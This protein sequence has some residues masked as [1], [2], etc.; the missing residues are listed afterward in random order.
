MYMKKSNFDK[1]YPLFSK[2]IADEQTRK[3]MLDNKDLYRK[4]Q[5]NYELIR[6]FLIELDNRF[7]ASVITKIITEIIFKYPDEIL[8]SYITAY[9]NSDETIKNK[10]NSFNDFKK[11]MFMGEDVIKYVSRNG[12][13]NDRSYKNIPERII[14]EKYDELKSGVEMYKN[15]LL[16]HVFKTLSIEKKKFVIDL[17]END[18]YYSFVE[19]FKE[20]SY[21]LVSILNLVENLNIGASLFYSSTLDFLDIKDIKRIV[22]EAINASYLKDDTLFMDNINTLLRNGKIRFLKEII[23]IDKLTDLN[24]ISRDEIGAVLFDDKYLEELDVVSYLNG[25]KQ[26][27]FLKLKEVA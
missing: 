4:C 18:S 5:D 7:E 15:E 27:T 19:C 14:D 10:E 24:E 1:K 2:Y 3:N 8:K 22:V 9:L 20:S 12:L 13:I 23:D 21:S 17:L 26:S 16:D 6:I 25:L 11:I